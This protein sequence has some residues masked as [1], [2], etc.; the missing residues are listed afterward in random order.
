MLS[1]YL[2]YVG[3]SK[4]FRLFYWV[5]VVN[6]PGG[7]RD[8]LRFRP[9]E[10][11]TFDPDAFVLS[12]PPSMQPFLQKILHLQIFQQFIS[13]RLDMLNS[14]DGFSDEFEI[15]ANMCNDKWGAQSRYKDWLNH[16]KVCLVCLQYDRRWNVFIN[17]SRMSHSGFIFDL[18]CNI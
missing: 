11:I 8:A 15:T 16:M 4:I 14:G 13:D 2:S 3:I 7:Y 12:R 10:R 5:S 1:E 17:C 18:I 6:M 9:G